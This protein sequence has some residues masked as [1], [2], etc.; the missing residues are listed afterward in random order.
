[1]FAGRTGEDRQ[2]AFLGRFQ[3]GRGPRFRSDSRCSSVRL[4]MALDGRGLFP[5]REEVKREKVRHSPFFEWL[6]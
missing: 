2:I 1:M 6:E 4:H 5:A 3:A